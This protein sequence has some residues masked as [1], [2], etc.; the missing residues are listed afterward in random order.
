[1]FGDGFTK[2]EQDKF[3]SE[4]KRIAEYVMDTSPWDEFADTIKIYALG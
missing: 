2:D 1:M 4:S 3:Y